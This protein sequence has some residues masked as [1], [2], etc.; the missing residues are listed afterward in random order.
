MVPV[1]NLLQRDRDLALLRQEY[2]AATGVLFKSKTPTKAE[3]LEAA[4]AAAE[5]AEKSQRAA[6]SARRGELRWKTAAQAKQSKSK[7]EARRRAALITKKAKALFARMEAKD[8]KRTLAELE[9][10]A[11]LLARARKRARTLSDKLVPLKAISASRLEKLNAAAMCRPCQV[12]SQAVA[13]VCNHTCV[14]PSFVLSARTRLGPFSA[15]EST[16]S[17]SSRSWRGAIATLHALAEFC[18]F[19]YTIDIYHT[20]HNHARR[21]TPQ[22]VRMRSLAPTSYNDIL[23]RYRYRY[24]RWL[25]IKKSFLVA[26]L[27]FVVAVL[28]LF[29]VYTCPHLQSA[30]KA[31]LASTD[32]SNVACANCVNAHQIDARL[33][34]ILATATTRLVTLSL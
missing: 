1:A 22:N 7:A 29:R 4:E 25:I 27:N 9:R 12:M 15:A 8:E 18:F 30:D 20:P 19:P 6:D 11:Q 17:S 13:R 23:Y 34:P 28:G 5:V 31:A 3:L 21:L 14:E 2:D 10:K 26:E 32:C 16:S 33:A 24:M